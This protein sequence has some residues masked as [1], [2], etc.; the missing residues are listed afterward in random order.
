MSLAETNPASA[1]FWDARYAGA[2]YIF[3][4]APNQ[5]L[6]SHA[7]LIQPGMRALAVADGEGRNSVWLAEHGAQMH[8]VDVS[9]LALEKARAL[10]KNRGVAVQFEQADL[11]NWHWPEAEYDLVVAI[12]IQ[13]ASPAQREPIIAGIRHALKPRGLLILQGYTAKQIEFATGGP[14][15]VENMYSES[16]LREWFGNW[17][18]RLLREHEDFIS[19]GSHHHGQSALIDLVVQKSGN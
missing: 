8:A 9:P 11:L 4:T 18:I 19:E 5:F 3:G 12:F 13:F 7:N 1:P 16:L 2:D 10:A 14:S 17:Q 15:S 6:A